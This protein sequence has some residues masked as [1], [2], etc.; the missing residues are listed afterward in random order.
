M[1]DG[2]PFVGPL[3][4]QR[5][6]NRV[7]EL[8]SQPDQRPTDPHPEVYNTSST[9]G[10]SSANSRLREFAAGPVMRE[11]ATYLRERCIL[12]PPTIPDERQSAGNTASADCTSEACVSSVIKTSEQKTLPSSQM[13]WGAFS[14]PRLRVILQPDVG[15]TQKEDI[16]GDRKAGAVDGESEESDGGEAL[17]SK[18]ADFGF[19]YDDSL[20]ERDSVWVRKE[21]RCGEGDTDA[22]L[23]CPGCFLPICYQCQRHESARH[24]FRAVAAFHVMIRP[25]GAEQLQQHLGEKEKLWKGRTSASD[26]PILQ[27]IVDRLTDHDSAQWQLQNEELNAINE[28]LC[29][30]CG[31]LVGWQD[32]EDIFHFMDVIPGEA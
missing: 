14:R 21:L 22:V 13:P 3:G 11:L 1:H 18:T 27:H 26:L 10:D 5:N 24:L 2:R 4:P 31:T 17:R 20:D 16:S 8:R 19:L 30:G 28:V 29:E 7:A 12:G 6:L 23:S 15:A 32:K 9:R 25:I